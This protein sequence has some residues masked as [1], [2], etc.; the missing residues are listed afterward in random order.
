MYVPSAL[1]FFGFVFGFRVF[2]LHLFAG[3]SETSLSLLIIGYGFLEI[4]LFEV[5]PI[6]IAEIKF[7]ICTLP[8]QLIAPPQLSSRAYHKLRVGHECRGEIF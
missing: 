2:C 4:F 5:G 3:F 1:L 7:G 6:G 8:Q